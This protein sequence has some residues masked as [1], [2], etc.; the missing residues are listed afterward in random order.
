[1]FSLCELCNPARYVDP[2]WMAV[3]RELET[4]SIDRHCFQHSNG[5]HVYRK[6]WEWT[7][8]IYGL[9]RLGAISPSSEALGVGAGREPVIFYLG[10]GRVRQVTAL[11]LYGNEVW[12]QNNGREATTDVIRHLERWCPRKMDFSRIRFVAGSGTKISFPDDTFDFCWSLSSIEH[13]GGHEAA[14]MSMREMA[15]VTKP[16]GIVALATEYLLLAEYSHPE[17]FNRQD[18]DASIIRASSALELVSEVDWS[19]LPTEYLIDSIPFP[20]G[21][22]RRRRHVVLNDGSLQWTSICLFFRKRDRNRLRTK[23]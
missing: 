6:G 2:E 13:F 17:Y 14:A 5:G 20:G 8:A 21:V 3:H 12:S 18:L 15:R 1:M 9:E 11:D 7:H 23:T 16:G 4:Y 10:D 19:T 22:E